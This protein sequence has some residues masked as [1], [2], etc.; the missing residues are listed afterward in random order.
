MQKEHKVMAKGNFITYVNLPK[1]YKFDLGDGFILTFPDNVNNNPL[2]IFVLNVDT[3]E[4][5][6]KEEDII[7][8]LKGFVNWFSLYFNAPCEDIELNEIVFEDSKGKRG[9]SVRSLFLAGSLEIK[10]T[11]VKKFGNIIKIQELNDSHKYCLELFRRARLMDDLYGNFWQIYII[12]LILLYDSDAGG[13][14]RGQIDKELRLCSPEMQ[15]LINDFNKKEGRKSDWTIFIAI[16][17]SFSHKST[18]SGEELDIDKELNENMENF[19]EIAR[20]IILDR[21]GIDI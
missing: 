14:E 12:M 20:K 21:L 3:V 17:D 7:N 18:F 5:P 19:L 6:V 11:D 16:R 10:D 15:I 9:M 2:K 8:K 4:E 13:S 1:T